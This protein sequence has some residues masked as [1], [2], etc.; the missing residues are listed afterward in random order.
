MELPDRLRRFVVDP[1][2]VPIEHALLS[3]AGC[4]PGSQV[5]EREAL[6]ALDGVAAMVSGATTGA[7]CDAV[8][9]GAGYR[10]D[11]SDYHDP[12]NSLLD[13]VISRRVGMPITLS[14]VVIA[15]ARRVGVA[16]DAIGAPGHFLIRDPER[17]EFRDPY[18]G[19]AR[20]DGAALRESL[21]RLHP[22][23][24]GV[25]DLLAPIGP[26]AI[27]SRVLNNLQNSY[28][29]RAV[30][31]LDWVLDVRLALPESVHGDPLLLATLCERRGRFGDA[32]RIFA[33]L[34]DRLDDDSMRDRADELSARLN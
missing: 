4:R 30:R 21:D 18:G 2:G 10:G 31:S 3:L 27:L 8:F 1:S 5:D 28:A 12:D 17:L 14:V 15:V 22:A 6:A 11:G 34:G 7:V 24:G 23:A 25:D 19:G 33:R 20:I 16:V 9:A 26:V 29:S 32:A 13:R